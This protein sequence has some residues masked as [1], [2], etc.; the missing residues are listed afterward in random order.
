[1]TKHR[2]LAQKFFEREQKSMGSVC[3]LLDWAVINN[4][5][6]TIV[7]QADDTPFILA[8]NNQYMAQIRCASFTLN[9]RQL[10]STIVES[11]IEEHHD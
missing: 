6:I 7:Y 11:Y 5:V 4:E 2:I 3:Q 1:M 9:G 10:Y 8:A